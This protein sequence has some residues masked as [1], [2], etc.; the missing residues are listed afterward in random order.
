A[1]ATRARIFAAAKRRFSQHSYEGVGLREIAADADVDAA[2]VIRYFGSKEALFREVA[3][4]AFSPSMLLDKGVAGLPKRT[5]RYLLGDLDERAWRAGY[6][7][8]RLLLC[9]IGSETA[10]PI[11][12]EHLDRGFIQPL[13]AALDGKQTH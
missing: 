1:D 13:A 7:P 12:A 10:G 4:Q 5:A 11:L 9:S 8:L 2:L 3:A 6:D